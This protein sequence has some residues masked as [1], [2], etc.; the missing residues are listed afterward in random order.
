MAAF[1]SPSVAPAC[2][3]KGGKCPCT[4]RASANSVPNME[5]VRQVRARNGTHTD[6]QLEGAMDEESADSYRTLLAETFFS[7]F[8]TG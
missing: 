2:S 8:R 3:P 7:P 1:P 6:Y 4:T 5:R